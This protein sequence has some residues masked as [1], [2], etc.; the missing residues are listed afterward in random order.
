MNVIH[1]KRAVPALPLYPSPVRPIDARAYNAAVMRVAFL[2]SE[3][4]K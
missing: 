3:E 1:A 2:T 4:S